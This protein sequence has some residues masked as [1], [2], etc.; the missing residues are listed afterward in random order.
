MLKTEL[1]ERVREAREKL[2]NALD[3]LDEE[4][5]SRTGLT[6]EWSIKDALA[7]INA[8]ELE[9]ARIVSEIQA[10]TWQPRRLDKQLIDDFNARVVEER[11]ERSFQELREEFDAAH[12]RIEEAVASLPDEVD[13]SA[14][15]YKYIEGVTLKHLPHHAA[16][17]EQFK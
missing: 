14:P 8:W 1:Q 13:E 10:G 17:I 12:A 5:A 3:G 9:G 2:V 16:Q 7:H 11:K 15:A 4:R 6:S